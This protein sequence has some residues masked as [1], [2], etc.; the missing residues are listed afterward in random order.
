MQFGNFALPKAL[1]QPG[2]SPGVGKPMTMTG[3]LPGMVTVPPVLVACTAK[4]LALRIESGR[5]QFWLKTEAVAVQG[6]YPNFTCPEPPIAKESW[7]EETS[8]YSNSIPC[9][10]TF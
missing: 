4:A 10:V 7:P 1:A 6:P 9:R 8:P 5:F 2:P 3:G